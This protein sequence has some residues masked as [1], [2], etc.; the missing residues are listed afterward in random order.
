MEK[1]TNPKFIDLPSGVRI[2][3]KNHS[4][5]MK[6]LS[7]ILFFNR[8]FMSGYWT[9]IFGRIYASTRTSMLRRPDRFEHWYRKTIKHEN[10]HAKDQRKYPVWFELTYILLPLPAG[11]AYGR[12]FWERR[13]YLPEILENTNDESRDARIKKIADNLGGWDYFLTWPK[14]W[15]RKWFNKQFQKSLTSS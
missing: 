8:S 10:I 7:W 2:Y 11:L 14:G 5:F 9:T 3:S 4:T 13:A 6:I 15:I 12:W 1:N